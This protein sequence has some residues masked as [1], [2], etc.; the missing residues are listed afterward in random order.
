M[1]TDSRE[2]RHE[3][4]RLRGPNADPKH[5]VLARITEAEKHLPALDRQRVEV[6]GRRDSEQ[7]TAFLTVLQDS[8][9][10]PFET[11]VRDLSGDPSLR[12]SR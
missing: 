12:D 2:I 11:L 1:S 10:L 6:R 9:G 4:P 5:E 8:L 3:L 7:R